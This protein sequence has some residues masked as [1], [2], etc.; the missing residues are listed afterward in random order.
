M[1]PMEMPPMRLAD[2]SADRCPA[3]AM[4]TM[5][6]SGTVMPARM[7]GTANRNISRFK[8]M[9]LERSDSGGLGD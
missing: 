1:V 4:S 3:T 5:P 8:F 2:A 9:T 7:L 6:T